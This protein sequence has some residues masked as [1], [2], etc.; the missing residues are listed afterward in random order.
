MGQ[1]SNLEAGFVV[2][3]VT[4]AFIIVYFG[5]LYAYERWQA[6]RKKNANL[7]VTEK[8]SASAQEG[9]N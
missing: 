2:P 9:E 6:R 5:L 7:P 1:L 4:I 8:D 3:V